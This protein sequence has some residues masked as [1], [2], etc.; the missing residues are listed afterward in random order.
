MFGASGSE[1][2]E[3]SASALECGSSRSLNSVESSAPPRRPVSIVSLYV[4]DLIG[5]TILQNKASGS[6]ISSRAVLGSPFP[7]VYHG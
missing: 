3:R 1:D 5:G 6:R 2:A 7:V 4:E